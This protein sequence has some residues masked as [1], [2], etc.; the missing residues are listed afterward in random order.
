MRS[1][2]KGA[3]KKVAPTT[4]TIKLTHNQY[5]YRINDKNNNEYGKDDKI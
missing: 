3:I 5:K 1:S 2:R 4:K